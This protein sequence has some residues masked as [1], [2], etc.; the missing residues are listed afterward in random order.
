L[1]H[2]EDG[3]A[4]VYPDGTQL[5]YRNGQ[6]HRD[7]GPSEVFPDGKQ[8]WYQNGFRVKDK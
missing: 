4:I 2:R 7:D 8:F 6:R 5:W 3:P 1:P